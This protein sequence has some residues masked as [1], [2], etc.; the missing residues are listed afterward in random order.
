[1]RRRTEGLRLL[2]DPVN[3]ILNVTDGAPKGQ[4]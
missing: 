4:G 2:G 1:M 3:P